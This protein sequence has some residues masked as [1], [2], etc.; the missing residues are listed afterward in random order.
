LNDSEIEVTQHIAR[1]HMDM[2][3]FSGLD[4]ME[5]GKVVAALNRVQEA[6]AKL[7]PTGVRSILNADERRSYLD[8]LRFDQIDT[9]HATIKTAHAKTCK[10]LLSKSEYQDWRDINKISEHHGLLWIKGKPGVGKSTIMKFACAV[11][12]KIMRDTGE[13]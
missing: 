13:H 5:Y 2:C 4:D 1:N 6:T 7:S 11:A 10:W 3:R 8:S 9:R 12:K